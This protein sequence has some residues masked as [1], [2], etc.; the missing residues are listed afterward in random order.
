MAAPMKTISR[1]VL[2]ALRANGDFDTYWP[3]H[4]KQEF[5]SNHQARYRDQLILTP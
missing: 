4:E 1:S 5:T 3:W 2:R